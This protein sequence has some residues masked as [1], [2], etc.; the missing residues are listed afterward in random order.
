MREVGDPALIGTR[1]REPGVA[2]SSQKDLAP[3]AKVTGGLLATT[4]TNLMQMA[5]EAQK[6]AAQNLRA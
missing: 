6:A 1:S 4:A 3:R 5:Y 2:P